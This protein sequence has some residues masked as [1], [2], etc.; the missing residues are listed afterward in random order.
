MNLQQI[1]LVAAFEQAH[2][3]LGESDEVVNQN[4]TNIMP[5]AST[6]TRKRLPSVRAKAAPT[7][8]R[9]RDRAHTMGNLAARPVIRRMVC[10]SSISRRRKDFFL[11]RVLSLTSDRMLLGLLVILRNTPSVKSIGEMCKRTKQ[12]VISP[13]QA[14]NWIRFIQIRLLPCRFQVWQA[15]WTVRSWSSERA[16][17][18]LPLPDWSLTYP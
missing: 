4:G 7:R 1:P 6:G 17:P 3:P 16:L 18:V 14:I 10:V 11:R 15:A 13:I 12:P 8:K 9:S 2:T 5:T